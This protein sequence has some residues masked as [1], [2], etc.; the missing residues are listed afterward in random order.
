MK[1]F[2]PNLDDV[3]III[4]FIPMCFVSWLVWQMIYDHYFV[5][6]LIVFC[7]WFVIPL[8]VWAIIVFLQSL[9]N[10]GRI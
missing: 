5:D 4:S 2:R 9:W 3:N 6:F 10:K 7:F 8:I 1:G